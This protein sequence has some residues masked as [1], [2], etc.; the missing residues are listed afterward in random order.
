MARKPE[1]RR[2]D[3]RERLI[4]LMERERVNKTE[5]SKQIEQRTGRII[6]P[7]CIGRLVKD[8]D[9]F[10]NLTD[11]RAKDIIEAYPE[12]RLTWL[13]GYDDYMTE[14]DAYFASLT[15][16]HDEE[17]DSLLYGLIAFANADGYKCSKVGNSIIIENRHGERTDLSG[18][19]LDNLI[20][21]LAGAI[22]G[23]V[24]RRIIRKLSEV[25]I[26]DKSNPAR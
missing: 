9:K 13:L 19:D 20:D 2:Y 22:G 23:I 12:Y 18:E 25:R 6:A 11:T 1:P 26:V 14:T 24:S 5:M 17:R 16:K 10:D 4:A 21:D 15:K 8:G 7:Q 3:R